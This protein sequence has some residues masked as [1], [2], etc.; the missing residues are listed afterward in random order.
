MRWMTILLLSLPALAVPA[1]AQDPVDARGWINKGVQEFKSARY[2]DAVES[3]QKAVD[4]DPNDVAARLYLATAWMSQYVP[5]A[6]VRENLEIANKAEVQLRQALQMEPHNAVGLSSLASLMYQRAM[7]IP[8]QEQKLRKLEEAASEYEK[9]IEADPSNKQGYYSLGVI[10]WVK[11]YATWMRTRTDLGMKPEEP[12]PM[13]DPA[14]QDLKLKYAAT[15]EHGISNLEKALQIDPQ[16]AD[17]MAYMNLLIR[18]RADLAGSPEQYRS[19]IETADHW[20]QKALETKKL[21]STCASAAHSRGR[22]DSRREPDP[23]GPTRLSKR[24]QE[25]R[26][27]GNGTVHG[28][29]R[30]RRTHP[31]PAARQR[32]S[33]TGR[34]CPRSSQSMGIQAHVAQRIRQWKWSREST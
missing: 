28:D 12:G 14:R 33:F 3:F 23:Q 34:C 31:E 4:L 22:K 20:V 10:D 29:H 25:S 27:S 21:Q 7:G 30:P 1:L 9:L 6:D 26:R 2:P 16:Y 32:R 17:A 8:D 24:C 13:P 19:E 15:I 18:E 11:W 5:G